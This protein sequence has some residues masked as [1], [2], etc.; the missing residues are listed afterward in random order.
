VTATELDALKALVA[1]EERRQ[2]SDGS[3]TSP[4]AD[5]DGVLPTEEDPMYSWISPRPYVHHYRF[6]V[7]FKDIQGRRRSLTFKTKDEASVW[8]DDAKKKLVSDGRPIEKVVDAYLASLTDHR[9]STLAT[10]RFRLVAV[11]KGRERLKIE[12]FPWINAWKERAAT[13]SRASQGGI[14]AALRGLLAFAKLPAKA[15]DGLKPTGEVRAGKEQ[16][17]VDEARRFVSV[18]FDAAD[19]LALAAATAIFTGCRASEVLSLT[20][21][22]VDDGGR[23]LHVR[24]TKTKKA[25]RPIDVDPALQPT[26]MAAKLGKKPDE[27]LFD[28]RPKRARAH[29]DALKA[30]R[31][32]LLRRVRALCKAADVKRVVSHSLRGTNATLRVA[33]GATDDTVTRALGWEDISTGHRNYIAP[34]VV[35][36]IEARKA[37]GRLLPPISTEATA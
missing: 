3:L 18:A 25:K 10:L 26:L 2:S 15:L 37:H 11:I 27:L 19:P 1:A 12:A 9:P 28:F 6:K 4:I 7:V 35:E 16:L 34:G 31:D 32:A 23:I 30:K 20:A 21:R 5:T 14:L 13:Q 22:D 17:T 8:I 36:Q 33:G 24:G 29:K